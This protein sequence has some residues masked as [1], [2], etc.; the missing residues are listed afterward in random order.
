MAKLDILNL[1]GEKVSDV[2]LS[3]NIWSIE[4]NQEV[5]KK[6]ID[7]QLSSLRQG[8]HKTKTRAEVAG[9][10][11]KPY[12]QKG[13]GRARHGSTRSPIWVGG[14]NAFAKTPRDYGFKSNKKEKVLALKSALT[15]K[16][17]DKKVTILDSLVLGNLKTKEGNKLL[18]TLKLEGKTLFVTIGD[19]ENLYMATRNLQKVEVILV[20]DLN[21]LDIV[22]AENLVIDQ[23]SVKYIEEVLK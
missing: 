17:S 21:V 16:L 23:E 3:D 13:T 10:G 7:L 11:R 14:G 4:P 20:E 12:R 6:A 18:E 2:K 9:G 8:T 1:K 5:L 15:N 19:A 22:N